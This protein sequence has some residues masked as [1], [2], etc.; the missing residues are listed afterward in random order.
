MSCVGK[1]EFHSE[2]V[3]MYP[4]HHRRLDDDGLNVS[5]LQ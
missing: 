3:L 2:R 1:K 5:E 4:P